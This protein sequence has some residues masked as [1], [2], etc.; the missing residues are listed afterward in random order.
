M[1]SSTDSSP[2]QEQ[3]HLTAFIEKLVQ[4]GDIV[5]DVGA[6]TGYR[7]EVMAKT[8]GDGGMVYAFEPHPENADALEARLMNGGLDN[9]RVYKFGLAHKDMNTCICK[10]EYGDVKNYFIS[11]HYEKPGKDDMMIEDNL[12]LAKTMV[13]C[14]PLDSLPVFGRISLLNIDVEGFE[15]MVVMGGIKTITKHRPVVVVSCNNTSMGLYSYN[16]GDL[17]ALIRTMNYEIYI[18]ASDHVC[19]PVDEIE[20]FERLMDGHIF[21]HTESN[22]HRLTKKIVIYEEETD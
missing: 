10:S 11:R 14:M 13:R 2:N 15:K 20:V 17:F 7:T 12:V 19:V 4:D 6:G 8:V 21:P 5:V 1:S 16:I 9:V 18:C 3:P 22:Q